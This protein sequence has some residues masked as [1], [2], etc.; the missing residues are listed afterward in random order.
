MADRRVAVIT[1]AGGA[2][3]RAIAL[4]LLGDGLAVVVSDLS[5]DRLADFAGVKGVSVVGGDITDRTV[6]AGLADEA[7]TRFGRVDVL[8]NNAG[9]P[10]RQRGVDECPDEEW[11]HSLA[12]YVTAPFAACRSAIPHMREA[13]GGL[14]V[15]VSSTAGWT[16]GA[17]GAAYTASEHALIGLSKNITAMYA[18]DGIRCVTVCPGLTQPDDAGVAQFR[19][20]PGSERGNQTVDRIRGAYLRRADPDEV[21]QLVAQLVRGGDA[22]LNGA[23]LTA[24]SGFSAYR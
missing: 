8:V 12:L 4:R 1:G 24:D 5:A 22:L 2:I 3:G 13:G 15:N 9:S 18:D 16:G 20:A 23:V 7:V 17:S 19:A 21:G 11:A 6:A 10:D 14:I